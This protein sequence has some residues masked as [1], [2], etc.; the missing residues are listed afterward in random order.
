MSTRVSRAKYASGWPKPR[1][2]PEGVLFVTTCVIEHSATGMRYAPVIWP[3][4]TNV[5]LIPGMKISP[6]PTSWIR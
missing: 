4:V 2:A 1:Y 3:A 5:G 6:E